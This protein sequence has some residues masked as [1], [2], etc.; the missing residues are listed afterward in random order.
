MSPVRTTLS[1]GCAPTAVLVGWGPWRADAALVGWFEHCAGAPSFFPGC[2]PGQ[3]ESRREAE[4]SCILWRVDG[5][6]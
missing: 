5:G 2:G 3:R 4:S 1:G 6:G